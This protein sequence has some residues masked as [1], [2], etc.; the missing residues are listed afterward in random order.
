MTDNEAS[1][2]IIFNYTYNG[3]SINFRISGSSFQE[4]YDAAPVRAER[5]LSAHFCAAL[6]DIFSGSSLDSEIR[7]INAKA[8]EEKLLVIKRAQQDRKN[9]RN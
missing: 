9:E 6:G 4:F 3:V 8:Q 1:K 2:E 5:Y 7:K